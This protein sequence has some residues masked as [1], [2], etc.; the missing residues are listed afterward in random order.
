M[1]QQEISVSSSTEEKSSSLKL[2]MP[3][4]LVRIFNY[5]YWPFWILFF[6]S[7]FYWLYNA[8]RMRS[9][10]YFTAANPGIELGGFFGESKINIL[11]KIASEFL[12]VTLFFEKNSSAE[13]VQGAMDQHGLRF[14]V[15]C[16]PDKGEM[17][18][19]VCKINDRAELELYLIDSTDKLIVQEFIT[20]ETE[21]GVLYFRFPDGSGSGITS[22][23]EKE[24]LH[25]T[26]DGF[27]TMEELINKSS[28]AR[29][30]LEFL[31][32]KFQ[33]KIFDVLPSGEKMLLQPIGNHCKGTKFMNGNKLINEKL[34]A[35]FDRIA[36]NMDGFY[37]GRFDLKVKSI[38]DLYN[39]TNIKIMEVNGV[40]SEPAHIYD[41]S[42]NLLGV[43]RDV[44]FNMGLVRKIA[45]QNQE[46]GFE[47]VPATE[48]LR[49]AFTHFKQK[50]NYGR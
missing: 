8:I 33:H 4:F 47:P 22:I 36:A 3:L 12:P 13:E 15:I 49:I 7:L 45:K 34:V 6:P 9:L 14:P 26:G 41:P 29:F 21:L 1:I 19:N 28:R 39:G 46:K 23:V 2:R 11:K 5:E 18:F 17:G 31:R 48:V 20:Y 37:F 32:N 10:T 24:F 50:A 16:K 40:T 27:S 35:V 42:M 30:Q 38:D 44:F 25:I 43:Y